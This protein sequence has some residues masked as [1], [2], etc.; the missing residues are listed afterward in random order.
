AGSFDGNRCS[1]HMRLLQLKATRA[2]AA[3]V[4]MVSMAACSKGTPVED[5]ALKR[6]LDLVG[7]QGLEL[8]PRS[9]TRMT[10]S[11]EELIPAGSR[12]TRPSARPA[13]ARTAAP[14][15]RTERAVAEAPRA[16]MPTRDTAIA[17]APATPRPS[18][19][20]AISPPPPGGYKTMG[21]LIR[22]AP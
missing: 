10:V 1:I 21:E 20:G 14:S 5:A 9:G 15:P 3:I 19:T 22:K 11:A 13:V 4:A 18:A 17:P 16:T 6:D 2:T 7:G 8:A 12:T